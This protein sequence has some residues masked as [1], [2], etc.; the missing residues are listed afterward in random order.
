MIT[1]YIKVITLVLV[2]PF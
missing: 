1:N 2:V